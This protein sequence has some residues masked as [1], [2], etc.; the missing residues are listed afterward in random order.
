VY[1]P[2]AAK[3]IKALLK[4]AAIATP[5]TFGDKIILPYPILLLT[6]HDV[7]MQRQPMRK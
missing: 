4:L 6:R 3:L 1:F 2:R 7:Q 5:A